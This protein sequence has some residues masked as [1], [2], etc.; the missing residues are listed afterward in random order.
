MIKIKTLKENEFF[1]VERSLERG[2]INLHFYIEKQFQGIY[3]KFNLEQ[4]SK[5]IEKLRLI[6]YACDDNII[7]PFDNLMF[8]CEI[9]CNKQQISELMTSLLRLKNEIEGEVNEKA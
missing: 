6:Y 2:Y 5:I 7:I 9:Q 1:I 3:R 4:T 8:H